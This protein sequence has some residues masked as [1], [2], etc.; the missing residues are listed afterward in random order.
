MAKALPKAWRKFADRYGADRAYWYV[1]KGLAITPEALKSRLQ[2]L[3]EFEGSTKPWRDLQQQYVHRLNVEK[4]SNADA[5]W[6]EAL[7]DS[8]QRAGLTDR[9]LRR[10]KGRKEFAL[11]IRGP[12]VPFEGLKNAELLAEFV[13]IGR[14]ALREI[15]ID[16]VRCVFGNERFPKPG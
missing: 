14:A 8:G 12:V 4:I 11:Q 3:K 10:M 9:K 7:H 15:P 6:P 1:P 5:E 13:R 16:A 2:I